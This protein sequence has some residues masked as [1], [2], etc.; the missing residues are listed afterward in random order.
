MAS[1]AIVIQRAF[2]RH[3]KWKDEIL[4][5]TTIALQAIA[6]GYL[7]RVKM[8]RRALQNAFVRHKRGHWNQ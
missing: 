5:R 4:I 6:R 8:R 3:R 7:F 1:A 2:R